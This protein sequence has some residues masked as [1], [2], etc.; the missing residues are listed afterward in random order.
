M[1][2]AR[3]SIVRPM[4][5]TIIP[6]LSL[7][8]PQSVTRSVNQATK[9]PT[10][11]VAMEVCDTPVHLA[12]DIIDESAQCAHT[13]R[14]YLSPLQRCQ[15]ITEASYWYLEMSW[16]VESMEMYTSYDACSMSRVSWYKFLQT[17]IVV[18]SPASF[19]AIAIKFNKRS[20]HSW[21]VSNYRGDHASLGTRNK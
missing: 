16:R 21:K 11:H 13:G 9:L 8:T 4:W 15:T 2:N 6:N 5:T 10:L 20:L 14:V 1:H 17:W 18:Q 19:R 3:V 12:I 7:Y